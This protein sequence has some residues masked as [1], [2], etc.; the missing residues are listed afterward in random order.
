MIS[1]DLLNIPEDALGSIYFQ[2][3]LTLV[4]N[5]EDAYIIQ[6]ILSK[7]TIFYENTSSTIFLIKVQKTTLA[8]SALAN[9]LA[10]LMDSDISISPKFYLVHMG[11]HRWST[12][13]L[14]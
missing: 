9:L 7:Y 8:L 1:S 12:S 3:E 11:N 10:I 13:K 2:F 14:V 5:L 6:N 4:V